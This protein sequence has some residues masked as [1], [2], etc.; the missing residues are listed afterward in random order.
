MV[1]VVW[2]E[3]W[4]WIGR[5]ATTHSPPSGLIDVCVRALSRPGKTSREEKR[6]LQAGCSGGMV[7]PAVGRSS[8]QGEI[9]IKTP[10]RCHQDIRPYGV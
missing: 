5:D 6:R 3:V 4:D 10:C 1:W 8:V 7:N 2:S 9:N